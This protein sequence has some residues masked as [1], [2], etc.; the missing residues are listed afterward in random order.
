MPFAELQPP[1]NL[2]IDPSEFGALKISW[3]PPDSQILLE[4]YEIILKNLTSSEEIQARKCR[5]LQSV[6]GNGSLQMKVLGT[7]TSAYFGNLIP[8]TFY[9]VDVFALSEDERSAPASLS[10]SPLVPG[11]PPTLPPDKVSW[12]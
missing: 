7:D 2:Q 4:A 11:M 9:R 1:R 3:H 12:S 6:V 8:D 10:S 5:H